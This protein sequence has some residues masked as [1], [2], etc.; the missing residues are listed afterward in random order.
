MNRLQ[1]LQIAVA[2]MKMRPEE[3]KHAQEAAPVLERMIAAI[4]RAREKD[5]AWIA[6]IK[7][8]SK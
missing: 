8:G 2:R 6:S 5:K 4:Q 1:A 7:K 3:D